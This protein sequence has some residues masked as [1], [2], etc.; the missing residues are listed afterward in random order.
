[1]ARLIADCEFMANAPRLS[2][3]AVVTVLLVVLVALPGHHPCRRDAAGVRWVV[4]IK[5]LLKCQELSHRAQ[6]V[7]ESL[8]AALQLSRIN[9][10]AAIGLAPPSRAASLR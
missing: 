6:Y 1:M 10:G 9:F 8:R 5:T 2:G 7:N 3:V 4:Y